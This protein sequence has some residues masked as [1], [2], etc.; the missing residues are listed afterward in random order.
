MRGNKKNR[1]FISVEQKERI[2][3]DFK[4]IIEYYT[5]KLRR[6]GISMRRV[7]RLNKKRCKKR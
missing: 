1:I 2:R 7:F 5:I 3:I 4:V 6:E